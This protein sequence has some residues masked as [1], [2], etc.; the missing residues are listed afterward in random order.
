MEPMG[1]DPKRNYGILL[2]LGTAAFNIINR[3]SITAT[4]VSGLGFRI[5]DTAT[6]V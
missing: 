6:R 4:T 1:K 3:S 5:T 2:I